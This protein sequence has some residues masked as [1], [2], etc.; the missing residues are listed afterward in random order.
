MGD[1]LRLG[2]QRASFRG[3]IPHSDEIGSRRKRQPV[4]LSPFH[5]SAKSVRKSAMQ[6]RWCNR[7]ADK[8]TATALASL[9]LWLIPALPQLP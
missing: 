6:S 7:S 8:V 3:E 5:V 9:N 4:F 1:C 2:E